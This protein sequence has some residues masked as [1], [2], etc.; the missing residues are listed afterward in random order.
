MANEIQFAAGLDPTVLD[1][2]LKAKM[3][4]SPKKKAAVTAQSAARLGLNLDDIGNVSGLLRTQEHIPYEERPEV[5]RIANA[6]DIKSPL[7]HSM[8]IGEEN[9]PRLFF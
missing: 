2:L 9:E 6:S 7:E 8:E 4:N 5:A 1:A 3:L